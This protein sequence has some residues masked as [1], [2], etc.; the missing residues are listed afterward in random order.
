MAAGAFIVLGLVAIAWASPI[1][2]ALLAVAA[3]VIW[4]SSSR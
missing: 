4:R 3:W 1:A 2:A